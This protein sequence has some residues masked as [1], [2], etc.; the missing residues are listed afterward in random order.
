MALLAGAAFGS[1]AAPPA[2]KKT[3]TKKAA[4]SSR[5]RRTSTSHKPVARAQ[6]SP[7]ASAAK[8]PTPRIPSKSGTRTTARRRTAARKTR[9]AVAHRSAQQQPTPERY[10]EIQEALANRGYFSGSPD[11]AWGADSVDALKRFQRDQNIPDDGKI[12]SL[13]LIAL[14]LGP[15]RAGAA[16]AGAEKVQR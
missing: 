8:T 6:V 9:P 15:N 2:K 10:K 11:G 13:S 7:K 5:H 1:Q 4:S 14:G 12:G 16:E 3:A